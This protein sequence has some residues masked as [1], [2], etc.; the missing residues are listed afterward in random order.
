M[1]EYYC[2]HIPPCCPRINSLESQLHAADEL[3]KTARQHQLK[4]LDI[5]LFKSFCLALAAY[6]KVRALDK[7]PKIS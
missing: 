6:E 7:S 1:S 4:A 5:D 2:S 3:A